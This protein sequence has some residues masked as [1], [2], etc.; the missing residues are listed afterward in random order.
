[1]V[2]PILSHFAEVSLGGF[3]SRSEERPLVIL[4]SE[5]TVSFAEIF[6]GL[7]L[8]TGPAKLVG[9]TTLGNAEMLGGY[10]FSD[11]SRVWV[12]EERFD[13]PVSYTD[14]ERDG[15]QPDLET[16]ADWDTFTFETDPGVA[17]ALT[18]LGHGQ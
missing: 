14:W 7:L 12:A 15:S 4:V 2:E 13:P 8:D 3:V 10:S 1:V 6:S 18:L 17:A 16:H 5:E 9:R 11:G